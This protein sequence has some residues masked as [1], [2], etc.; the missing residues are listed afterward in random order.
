MSR[1]PSLRSHDIIRALRRAGFEEHRHRG[2]H[3]IF[4]K[5]I[6]RVTVPIHSRDLKRGTLRSIIDQAGLTVGEFMELLR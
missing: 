4:K 6:L 1:L 2:S 5:G 3:R